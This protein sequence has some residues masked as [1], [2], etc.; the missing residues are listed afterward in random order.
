[1]SRRETII[2]PLAAAVYCEDCKM[3][4]NT[5]DSTC[6]CGSHAVINLAHL[7]SARVFHLKA[8]DG[9]IVQVERGTVTVLSSDEYAPI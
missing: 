2:L 3:V 1:M 9:A 6:Y 4:T 7:L 8:T 5:T